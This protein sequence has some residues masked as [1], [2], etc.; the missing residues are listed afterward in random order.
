MEN[1]T[2]DQK[3]QW[4]GRGVAQCALPEQD[5]GFHSQ[6]KTKQ[7]KRATKERS[8]MHNKIIFGK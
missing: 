2:V 7:N 5:P 6:H 8:K 4:K 1:K 3:I